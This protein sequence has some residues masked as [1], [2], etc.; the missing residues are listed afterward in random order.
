[1]KK[2][3]LSIFLSAVIAAGCIPTTALAA[4]P[5]HVL[6]LGDS[7]TTGYGLSDAKTERFP[8]LLGN[9]TLIT[10]KAVNG[11]TA[12]GIV[13]QLQK[14]TIS[15]ADISSADFITITAGGNDVMQLL[16]SQMAEMHHAAYHSNMK[17]ADVRK[18]MNELNQSNL[19]QHHALLKIAEQRPAECK[20]VKT[21]RDG[22]AIEFEVPKRWI[23]VSPP[24]TVNM[25]DEQRQKAA[26]R[27][28]E[29]RAKR[30]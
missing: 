2:R 9:D 29:M 30:E 20:V 22:A 23:K 13:S 10:N 16:Y 4:S 25:T 15:A 27:L 19:L 21:A 18:I 1:M 17:A 3:I 24:K 6:A 7:I 12:A 26:A 28:A 11:N 5:T 14:G 8:S